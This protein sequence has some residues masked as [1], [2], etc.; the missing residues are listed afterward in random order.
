MGLGAIRLGCCWLW[1]CHCWWCHRCGQSRW[2]QVVSRGTDLHCSGG[3]GMGDVGRGWILVG[4]AVRRVS[5]ALASSLVAAASALGRAWPSSSRCRGPFDYVRRAVVVV[6]ESRWEV[7]S[8]GVLGGRLVGSVFR[9][10]LALTTLEASAPSGG[11]PVN[12]RR[13][14]R[15]HG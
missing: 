3:C 14:L 6:L 9:R 13:G 1:R 2:V 11:V 15:T 10:G 7:S 8:L 4:S 12:R 5:V